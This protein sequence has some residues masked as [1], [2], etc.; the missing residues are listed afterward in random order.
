VVDGRL[1]GI[2]SWTIGC[3]AHP[4]FFTRIQSYTRVSSYPTG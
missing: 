1:A 4:A 3:G 2:V